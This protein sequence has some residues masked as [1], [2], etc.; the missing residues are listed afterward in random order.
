MSR[1]HT[2]RH[3]ARAP[4]LEVAYSSDYSAVPFYRATSEPGAQ[5]APAAPVGSSE[6]TIDLDLSPYG[7]Q[8][9][10]DGRVEVFSD[11]LLVM[12][13]SLHTAFVT[14]NGYLQFDKAAV[15]IACEDTQHRIYSAATKVEMFLT[16][17]DD[18]PALNA[19]LPAVRYGPTR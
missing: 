13:I 7:I 1:T 8:L 10:G 9:R 12:A 16:P 15:D 3:P 14:N 2:H 4:Q 11:E 19:P 17:M 5:G 6:T 18:V